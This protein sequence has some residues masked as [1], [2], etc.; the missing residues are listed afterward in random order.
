MTSSYDPTWPIAAV[1]PTRSATLTQVSAPA[2]CFTSECAN[3]NGETTPPFSSDDSSDG[4][5]PLYLVLIIV[6]GVLMIVGGAVGIFFGSRGSG[7]AS[8]GCCKRQKKT[9]LKGLQQQS[10]YYN[11]DEPGAELTSNPARPSQWNRI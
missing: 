7:S 8:C 3:V 6:G 5:K 2:D 9:D 4:I 11:T 10:N 1:D